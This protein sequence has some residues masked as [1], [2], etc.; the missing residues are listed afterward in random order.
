MPRV[1]IV[2]ASA[3]GLRCAAR[4]VRLR[5]EWPVTVVERREVFSYAACGLPYVLSGDIDQLDELRKT[6]YDVVRDE[7]FFEAY[8]GFEVLAGWSAEV[9][10]PHAGTLTVRRD[11]EERTLEWDELV[12]ATG[13]HPTELPNQ[14]Q[15]PHVL[16]FHTWDDVVPLKQGL[17]RGEIEHVAVVGA[18]PVGCELA[19]AFTSLWGAEV[20]LIEAGPHPLPQVVDEAAGRLIA[21]E[22][23]NNDVRVVCDSPIETIEPTDDGVRLITP[24]GDVEADAAV[25]A[26]GVR[27]DTRLGEEIGVELGPTGAIAVD[28]R[29]ATSVPHVWA[30]GDCIEVELAVLGRRAHVP[31]GSLANRQGRLLADVLAGRDVTFPSVSGAMA[32]KVFDR[33]VVA[34]GCPRTS[35]EDSGHRVDTVWVTTHDRAHY[36]PEAEDLHLQLSFDL[37]TGQVLGIQG[38]GC[39]EVVKRIDVASQVI[40]RGG[41]I[42]ELAVVEH[43]YAPPV[44]PAIDPLALAAFCA[45][46]RRDGVVS[47][48]PLSDPAGR[49]VLDV[50]GEDEREA[51]PWVNGDVTVVELGELRRRVSELDAEVPWLVVCERGT[52]SAE[53][54]RWLSQRGFDAVY[55]GGGVAW[56]TD[57]AVGG[58]DA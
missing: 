36:W 26:V 40:A 45:Q 13:A 20:T 34:A 54:A 5:P 1:V 14:P 25:V 48:S 43:A 3:A 23:E 57:A 35:L 55:L 6:A 52:R 11:G 4:L 51:H 28:G 44:A 22:L 9:V 42:D 32:V 18:G 30:A 2:G 17:I 33:V 49:S 12:L 38:V 47:V 24:A 39:N 58:E 46:S 27:P 29:L 15:H 37:D 41:T 16:A 21:A 53:A 7:T 50:R 8:K 10:D 56:R 19:E 31:L